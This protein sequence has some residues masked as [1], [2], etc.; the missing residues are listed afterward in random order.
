MVVAEE[1]EHFIDQYKIEGQSSTDAFKATY[2]AEDADSGRQVLLGILHESLAAD[3]AF[4]RAFSQRSESLTQVR[5]ANLEQVLG[6]GHTLAGL[7]YVAAEPIDGYPLADRLARLRQQGATAHVVYA[8]T[9]VR[10]IASG[11]ALTEKLGLTH[12][13]LTP[14][15][16]LLKNIT[17][18]T[19]DSAV[20]IDLDIPPDPLA[21]EASGGVAENPYLSPEQ[22]AGKEPS[23]A[24]QVYSLGAILFELLS[25]A[26]PT[27]ASSQLTRLK[28]WLGG[29]ASLAAPGTELTSETHELVER[30]LKKNPRRRFGSVAG[31]LS[32]LDGALEAEELRI[33]TGQYQPPAASRPLFLAPLLL[34]LLCLVLALVAQRFLP[35]L[36]GASELTE[37]DDP[38]AAAVGVV[39]DPSL[40]PGPTTEPATATVEWPT[41]TATVAAATVTPLSAIA[42]PLELTATPN[43][44]STS[45]PTAAPPTATPAPPTVTATPSATPLPAFEVAVSS[46]NLRLGPGTIY[47]AIGFVLQG[48]T[49]LVLARSAGSFIWYNVR[50]ADGRTGWLAADV[51][52][53]TGPDGLADIEVAATIPPA[54]TPT[55]TPT[56]TNTPIPTLTPGAEEADPGVGGG[57]G[58]GGGSSGGGSRPRPT[59][60]PAL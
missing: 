41:A 18:K 50:T 5:H 43:P 25:G 20:V 21:Q 32:A 14:D 46:A 39:T 36:P 51:G 2:M 15:H 17:L 56:P 40:T 8:L 54:P 4:A 55:A 57:S 44:T 23:G 53:A 33:R 26:P 48:E 60:T 28:S 12:Y 49:V 45:S 34:L 59:P 9:L 31:F 11:L 22:R 30:A 16:I 10:Q 47:E 29:R 37:G 7:P 27:A 58:S 38:P 19:D 35:V 13:Q 24:S 52:S 3:L 42:A 1:A 6:S